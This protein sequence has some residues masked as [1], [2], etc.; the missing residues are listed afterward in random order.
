MEDRKATLAP[1]IPGM[2]PGQTSC[3]DGGSGPEER[4]SETVFF[5]PLGHYLLPHVLRSVGHALTVQNCIKGGGQE[6][7]SS[8]E[9]SPTFKFN[10]FSI[11]S[12]TM[13][14]FLLSSVLT[15]LAAVANATLTCSAACQVNSA[16][17]YTAIVAVTASPVPQGGVKVRYFSIVGGTAM[18]S[19]YHFNGTSGTQTVSIQAGTIVAATASDAIPSDDGDAPVECGCAAGTP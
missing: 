19:T 13:K 14:L 15:A 3:T 6:V 18:L 17:Q 2:N 11:L 5:T 1:A 16:G 8:L 12:V 7:G 9:L 10:N 4:R